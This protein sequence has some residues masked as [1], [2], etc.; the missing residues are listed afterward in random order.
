MSESRQQFVDLLHERDFS[1][2]D[3]IME[4]IEGKDAASVAQ[5][6]YKV[7][8]IEG[9]EQ[10]ILNHPDRNYSLVLQQ[11]IACQDSGMGLWLLEHTPNTT[12]GR[13]DITT[14]RTLKD[15]VD[16]QLYLAMIERQSQHLEPRFLMV[17]ADY[18]KREDFA[19]QAVDQLQHFPLYSDR[20]EAWE[21]DFLV[22][23]VSFKSIS[24]LENLFVRCPHKIIVHTLVLEIC[25]TLYR[26]SEYVD[27]LDEALDRYEPNAKQIEQLNQTI[28]NLTEYRSDDVDVVRRLLP[29]YQPAFNDG[30]ILS[31]AL[32]LDNEEF[33]LLLLDATP[34]DVQKR[35]LADITRPGLMN[36]PP[37]LH[38]LQ[39]RISDLDVRTKLQHEV[40]GVVA[41]PKKRVL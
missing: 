26:P 35:V 39:N 1:T 11:L 5:I 33:F 7:K 19:F 2:F 30:E 32:Y 10:I 4:S 20:L 40:G 24:L 29:Y 41:L 3:N 34:L 31:S 18:H 28:L 15:K 12:I 38:I 17:S 16:D 6:A 14:Y 9:F 23:L 25:E 37:H 36:T 22:K 13:W 27:I 21:V 8:H